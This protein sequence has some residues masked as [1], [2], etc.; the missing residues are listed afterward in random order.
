VRVLKDKDGNEYFEH[1][2]PDVVTVL[3]GET[4][5]FEWKHQPIRICG[6]A[7]VDTTRGIVYYP[8]NNFMKLDG[9][10]TAITSVL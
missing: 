4:F 3:P 6:Y 8:P 10:F 2:S 1:P 7:A 5:D 9:W